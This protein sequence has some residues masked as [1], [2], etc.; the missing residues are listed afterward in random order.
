MPDGFRQIHEP[1]GGFARTEPQAVH[2][3]SAR[4]KRLGAVAGGRWDLCQRPALARPDALQRILPRG[5]R[6]RL[7]SLPP[8]RLDGVDCALPQR[9][10]VRVTV[11]LST[12]PSRSRLGN[13]V[14]LLSR[15]RKQAVVITV[16]WPHTK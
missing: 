2:S 8:D 9:S 3:L 1:A 10:L 5:H 11:G 15:T 14:R 7:R 4:F 13:E 6:A 12:A 16:A